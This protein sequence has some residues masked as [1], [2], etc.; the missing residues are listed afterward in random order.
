MRV[1]REKYKYFLK[2][3]EIDSKYNAVL[4]QKV[5]KIRSTNDKKKRILQ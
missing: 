2:Q 4:N 3:I 5:T 1:R